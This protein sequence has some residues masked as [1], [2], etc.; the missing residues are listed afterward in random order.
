M[1]L[2]S[3]VWLPQLI[4]PCWCSVCVRP[5]AVSSMLCRTELE[6][7]TSYKLHC[8]CL[9]SFYRDIHIADMRILHYVT[10]QAWGSVVK[11]ISIW[12]KA[13]TNMTSH[14]C[15]TGVRGNAEDRGFMVFISDSLTCYSW[16]LCDLILTLSRLW[17]SL[18]IPVCVCEYLSVSCHR[19]RPSVS[20]QRSPPA[21]SI[22]VENMKHEPLDTHT[23]TWK[24]SIYLHACIYFCVL[25]FREAEKFW[26]GSMFTYPDW[27]AQVVRRQQIFTFN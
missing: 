11:W 13:A 16:S 9:K 7:L 10:F 20:G 8:R 6:S 3:G 17:V 21:R 1:K 5:R 22:W 27:V 18:F 15:Q 23:H 2:F 25:P 12:K 14:I 24:M 19:S 26:N 4:P